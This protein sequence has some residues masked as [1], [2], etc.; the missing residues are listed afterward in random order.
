MSMDLFNMDITNAVALGKRHG[1]IVL[2]FP[3]NVNVFPTFCNSY[4]YID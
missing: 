4:I 1:S 3:I 2:G